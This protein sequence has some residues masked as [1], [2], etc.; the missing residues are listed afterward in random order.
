MQNSLYHMFLFS[1]KHK[2]NGIDGK[3]HKAHPQRHAKNSK[4][5]RTTCGAK[6]YKKVG[7]HRKGIKTEKQQI[8]QKEHGFSARFQLRGTKN[9]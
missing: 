1:T 8:K 7:Q 3:T 2:Y 9:S 4:T 6:Q 5:K